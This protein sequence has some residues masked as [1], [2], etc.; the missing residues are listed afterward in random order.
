MTNLAPCPDCKMIISLSAAAC[1]NCG[2][3]INAGDLIP[4][5]IHPM[6]IAKRP[7]PISKVT[8]FIIFIV[9]L[10][11]M[12]ALLNGMEQLKEDERNRQRILEMEQRRSRY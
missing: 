5:P 11:I 9:V 8:I 10:I 6:P 3:P 4:V 2:R 7:K 1:P 12:V